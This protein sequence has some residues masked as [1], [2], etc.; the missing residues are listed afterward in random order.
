LV[1]FVVKHLALTRYSQEDGTMA[2]HLTLKCDPQYKDALLRHPLLSSHGNAKPKEHNVS[3]TFFDTPDLSLRHNDLGLRVRH[4]DGSWIQHIERNGNMHEHHQWEAPVAGPAPDLA[5]LHKLVNDKK[6]R[7]QVLCAAAVGKRLAPVFTTRV[8]RTAWEVAPHNGARIA[9]AFEQGR[10][11]SGDK[12]TAISELDLELTAGEPAQLFDLAL[13]LQRDFPLHIGN[14][15]QAER[16]YALIEA[17]A[18]RAVKATPLVLGRAMSAEEGFQAIAAN[19]LA[20]MQA[21]ADGV[22]DINDV[23]AVHQMRVGMRRLHS[24]LRMFRDV[25]RLP[26]ELQK[27]LDWLAGELGGA[28]DWD[29]LAGSTLATVAAQAAEPQAIEEVRQAAAAKARDHHVAAAAAVGAARYTEL[30]LGMT[31]WVQAMGWHDDPAA[32]AKGAAQLTGSVVKFARATG[33]RDQRRLRKRAANLSSA[34]PEARHRVRIAAKKARYGAEFFGSLF[35]AKDVRPYVKALS[36]LQDE[37]GYLNDA[38]VAA[39]LLDQLAAA[40]P[41]LAANAGFAKGF[42]AARAQNDEKKVPKLWRKVEPVAR[43]R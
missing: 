14:Q 10:V 19:A 40:R 17:R 23:E 31:R 36:G 33:K 8:R 3:E 16:G 9:C 41:E 28:R 42:L 39:G 20:Q 32:T 43:P 11:E 30:M 7:R 18:T 6:I 5:G 2:D 29:V 38:A 25:L 13:A 22:A 4:E 27:E 24:A 15:S 26:D 12:K 1:Q 35:A 37:L 34:T 21:N